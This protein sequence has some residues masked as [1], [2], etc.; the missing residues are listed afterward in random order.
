MDKWS[1]K[2]QCKLGK[3]NIKLIMI[4][5]HQIL[6]KDWKGIWLCYSEKKFIPQ[7]TDPNKKGI[8]KDVLLKGTSSVTWS[9]F[10]SGLVQ[11]RNG[12]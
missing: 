3:I 4:K 9:T 12:T 1:S 2:A 7:A 10:L 11:R 5:S 6:T 8:L